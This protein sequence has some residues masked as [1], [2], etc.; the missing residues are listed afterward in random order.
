MKSCHRLPLAVE[1]IIFLRE[2]KGGVENPLAGSLVASRRYPK[3]EAALNAATSFAV[4]YGVPRY[5]GD[6]NQ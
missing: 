5:L 2:S 4:Q 3:E 6:D 1:V